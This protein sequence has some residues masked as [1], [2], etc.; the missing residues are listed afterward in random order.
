[1]KHISFCFLVVILLTN[2]S[3][4]K[5]TY[6][7]PLRTN[8]GNL[9][10]VADPCVY[11]VDGTYYLSCSSDEGFTYYTSQDL[12]TWDSCGILY[13]IPDNDSIRTCLWASEVCAH[14]GKFYLTYSGYDPRC[15]KLVICLAVSDS[16]TGPFTPAYTPWI[17]QEESHSID[18]H[19]FF[20]TDNTPYVYF[21]DNGSRDEFTGGYG[22]LRMARLKADMSGIEGP[23]LHVNDE[24]QDWEKRSFERHLSCNEGATVFLYNGTYYMTYSANETH[25]GDYAVGVQT[26]PTPLGPWKK[27]DYNPILQTSYDRPERSEG[28]LPIV[29]SP[30]HNGLVIG[31]NGKN[32][33]LIYHRHAPRVSEYPSNDRVTCLDRIWIDEDGR[34]HTSGPSTEPQDFPE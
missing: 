10:Y 14:N 3:C 33:Y 11:Q 20:D 17:K 28:G 6:T 9:L 16:P 5:R 2:I 18:A 13:R 24:M 19:I 32:M 7:N 23:I 15:D 4:T 26:A 8:S 12:V 21:S 30:G 25:L 22:G 27:E 31:P 29:S 1:M 34:V